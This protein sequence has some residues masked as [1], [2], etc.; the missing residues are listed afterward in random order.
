MTETEIADAVA[1]APYWY[2]RIELPGVTTPGW[3]PIDD[4]AYRLPE[5]FDGERILDIGSWDGY[6]TWYALQRG[7]S[8]V[9]A[10]D[11]HSDTL[12][13]TANVD[14]S[15]KWQTWDLCQA[16][17]GYKHCQR[18]T[19]SVYDIERL[20]I[21]FD[22]VFCFG[23]LYHLKHPTWALEQ[24]RSVTTKAIH[25]ESAVL[26]NIQSPY[27]GEGCQSGAC[28][29]EYYPGTEYGAN[30]SNWTVPTLKCIDAWL[31]STGWGNVETWKLTD[32]PMA[33]SHCRG[34][35][36]AVAV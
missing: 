1:A 9:V 5:R 17:F 15:S 8:Y 31:R 20:G 10:I 25:I 2:H 18:I 36:H 28:H 22:R 12:G 35:A 11:D 23:V 29:A 33:I 21:E 13:T 4:K 6:W 19:M 32:M 26:D 16:A 7:A 27:T 30:A 3:A 24:L 34:F 14:R